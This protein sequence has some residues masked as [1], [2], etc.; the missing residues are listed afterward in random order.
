MPLTA[1]HTKAVV[2]LS[3]YTGR[4]TQTK[5]KIGKET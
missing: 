3:V 4:T 5:E 1:W 2:T